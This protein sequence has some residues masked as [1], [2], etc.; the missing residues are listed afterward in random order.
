MDYFDPATFMNVF[1]ASSVGGRHP[2]DNIDWTNAY[3]KANGT[4]DLAS[5]AT[6]MQASE[7]DMVDSAAWF[8]L[9]GGFGISLVPCNLVGPTSEPNKNGYRFFGGGGPGVLH[10][11]EGLYWSNSTCRAA[12]NK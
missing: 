11:M 6:A 3:N 9:Y 5:R 1:R 2:Y 8:F 7:K 12:I 4:L 10:M